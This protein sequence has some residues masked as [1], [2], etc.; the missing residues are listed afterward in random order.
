MRKSW[1]L[2]LLLLIPVIA[3][4]AFSVGGIDDPA[5]VGGIDNP[6]SVG[7]IDAGSGSTP[8][9]VVLLPTADSATYN[10]WYASSGTDKYALV[11]DPVGAEDGNATYIW[12]NGQNS[13]Q[14]FTNLPSLPAGT[15]L[16]VSVCAYAA[17]DTGV[18][19][20]QF[21][22]RVNGSSSHSSATTVTTSYTEYCNE[23]TT[24][25]VSSSAWTEADVEGTSGNP[26]QDWGVNTTQTDAQ[27][28][29]TAVRLKV[30][31]N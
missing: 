12:Y 19:T 6:A 11:D 28:R 8:G 3:L 7:G 27:I 14:R 13:S 1:P 31:Y 20:I 26:L 4:A 10:A 24:N 9:D 25:P 5:S 22:I 30:R 23:W 29:A 15:I 16:G 17:C 18:N 2:L 21:S